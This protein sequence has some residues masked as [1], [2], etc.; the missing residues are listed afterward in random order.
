MSIVERI[1]GHSTLGKKELKEAP[2]NSEK[3]WAAILVGILFALFSSNLMY[4]ITDSFL[5]GMNLNTFT[6]NCGGPT[7]FGLIL[8][9]IIFTLIIRIL[10]L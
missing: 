10:M 4:G 5:S 9:T 3:W 1:L 6:G 8:H 7:I 2:T